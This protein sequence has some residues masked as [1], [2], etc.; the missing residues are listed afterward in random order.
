MFRIA[1]TLGFGLLFVIP[2]Q[3]DDKKVEFTEVAKGFNKNR[4]LQSE[5]PSASGVGRIAD[6]KAFEKLWKAWQEGEVPKVDFDKE[7]I[8]VATTGS[9]NIIKLT[10]TLDD[11]GDLKTKASYTRRGGPGFTFLIVKVK[12]DGVKSINGEKV[13]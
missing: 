11:K 3:A 1:M 12:R 9:N 13:K 5:A 8:L 2:I 4:K 7:I 10:C 6:A